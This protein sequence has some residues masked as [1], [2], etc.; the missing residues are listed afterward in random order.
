MKPCIR[1]S[2][3]TE[4]IVSIVP[5]YLCIIIIL[6]V[7]EEEQGNDWLY[8]VIA[9]IVLAHNAAIDSVCSVM[10][11]RKLAT[12]THLMPDE[13]SWIYLDEVDEM[14]CIIGELTE[15]DY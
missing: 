6:D 7:E 15:Y 4:S 12:Q 14:T 10:E 2:V 8:T 13:P 11:T 1:A 9:D 5:A 3:P